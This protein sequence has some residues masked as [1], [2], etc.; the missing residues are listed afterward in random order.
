MKKTLTGEYAIMKST[1]HILLSLEGNV[2]RLTL[3]R[4]DVINAF[5]NQMRK[6][7]PRM[8]RELQAEE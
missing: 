7:F 4:P 5:N 1:E 8:I 3:N 2:A 6:D